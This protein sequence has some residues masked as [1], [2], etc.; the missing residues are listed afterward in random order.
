MAGVHPQ[1]PHSL[2]RVRSD[3]AR[4]IFAPLLTNAELPIVDGA[5]AFSWVKLPG[6][7]AGPP[8]PM[9]NIGEHYRCGGGPRTQG[10]DAPVGRPHASPLE[11]LC[12]GGSQLQRAPQTRHRRP[13]ACSVATLAPPNT[14]SSPLTQPSTPGTSACGLSLTQPCARAAPA[15]IAPASTAP[16]KAACASATAW[17]TSPE[18]G[19]TLRSSA[20]GLRVWGAPWD[21]PCWE[22]QQ[23]GS[24][25]AGI[26]RKPWPSTPCPAPHGPLPAA[27][28][29]T[30][31]PNPAPPQVFQVLRPRPCPGPNARR[32][33]ARDPLWPGL[34]E[35]ALAARHA[36]GSGWPQKFLHGRHGHPGGDEG[37]ACGRGGAGCGHLMRTP[38]AAVQAG[39]APCVERARE[40][41]R[42]MCIQSASVTRAGMALKGDALR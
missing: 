18:G 37:A 20:L 14:G 15:T 34:R 11:R 27:P 7:G 10:P 19:A 12:W 3:L 30:T 42:D 23:A 8:H 17:P 16:S 41:E 26:S 36:A 38:R 4:G 28:T 1:H 6:D 40:G 5:A 24:P 35:A 29:P 32:V 9:F 22:Q 13:H 25:A 39:H 33:R 21:R 2:A 31:G